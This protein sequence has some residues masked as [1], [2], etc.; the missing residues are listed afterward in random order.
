[1]RA[2]PPFSG[3]GDGRSLAGRPG[4]VNARGDRAC[5]SPRRWLAPPAA[6]LILDTRVGRR[7]DS[8]V[9]VSRRPR[10]RILAAGAEDHDV[11]ERSR[12][13]FRQAV[14]D[15]A[16]A[17]N[18]SGTGS[19]DWA[20]FAAQQAAEKTLKAL[21]ARLGGESWGHSLLTTVT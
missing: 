8:T 9:S 11:A 21:I 7:P 5:R 4:T 19:H 15:L 20:C 6:W 3:F 16:H 14:H 13:W 1:M 17:R 10:A 18:A 2:R 12:D